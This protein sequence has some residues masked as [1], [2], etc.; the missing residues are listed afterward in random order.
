MKETALAYI[1]GFFDAEGSV[2]IAK[3]G[4][5]Q[6]DKKWYALRATLSSIDRQAIERLQEM[7]S[8]YILKKEYNNGKQASLYTW[9]VETKKAEEFFKA[10]EPYSRVKHDRIVLALQLRETKIDKNTRFRSRYL[11]KEVRQKRA[12]I[13]AALTRLN[14]R[15]RNQCAI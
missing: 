4:N 10:I 15:G 12:A 13:A 3:K 1:A 2:V 6:T 5:G 8:G 9:N 11:T 7:F 14:H